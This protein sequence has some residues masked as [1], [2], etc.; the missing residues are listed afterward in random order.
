MAN[1]CINLAVEPVVRSRELD[2]GESGN[3]SRVKLLT[4]DLLT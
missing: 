2:T 3:V 4:V 1:C